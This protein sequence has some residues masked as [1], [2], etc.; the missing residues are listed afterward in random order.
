[1]TDPGAIAGALGGFGLF[2]P[3]LSDVRNADPEDPERRA[4]VRLGEALGLGWSG[5]VVLAI[6][7]QEGSWRPLLW[8]AL[9]AA[10]LVTLWESCLAARRP[11]SAS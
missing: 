3:G 6:A 9:G 1:M 5:L 4:D 11:E 10:A 8:W 2:A 7:Y